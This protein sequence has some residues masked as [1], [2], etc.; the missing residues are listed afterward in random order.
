MKPLPSWTSGSREAG[1]GKPWVLLRPTRL[2]RSCLSRCS[3]VVAPPPQTHAATKGADW[4]EWVQ[5]NPQI[6]NKLGYRE[7]NLNSF[8]I[9]LLPPP[10][11]TKL[12]GEGLNRATNGRLRHH[13]LDGGQGAPDARPDD[14][15]GLDGQL[16]RQ[17]VKGVVAEA[18]QCVHLL[19]RSFVRSTTPAKGEKYHRQ[20]TREPRKA[21]SKQAPNLKFLENYKNVV[22]ASSRL[23]G[24]CIEEK[25]Y[26]PHR[27]GPSTTLPTDQQPLVRTRVDTKQASAAAAGVGVRKIR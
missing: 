4:C 23:L 25:G 1:T 15:A 11:K 19:I 26:L 20:T 2:G 24:G 22:R 8:Y 3:P 14:V 17:P 27:T 6:S 12:E 9:A 5:E 16:L 7:H 10:W 21:A 18:D 13:L